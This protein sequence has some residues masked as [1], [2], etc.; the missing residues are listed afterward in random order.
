MKWPA[1][2]QLSTLMPL[3]DGYRLEL[4]DRSDIAPLI[5]AIR[6]WHPEISVG[7]NSC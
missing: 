3:P 5:E 7:A 2:D 1:T 6:A 4:V